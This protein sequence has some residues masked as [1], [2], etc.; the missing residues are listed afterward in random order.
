MQSLYCAYV[1]FS[2]ISVAFAHCYRNCKH[3]I[4]VRNNK[5]KVYFKNINIHTYMCICMIV[6]V[7]LAL[8]VKS[9]V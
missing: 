2:F 3:M 4:F 9:F 1:H 5:V 7:E 8:N 6:Y